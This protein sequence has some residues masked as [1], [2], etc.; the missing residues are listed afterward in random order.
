MPTNAK[1][2][3]LG[4][5]RPSRRRRSWKLCSPSQIAERK[6]NSGKLTAAVIAPV[7]H[8]QMSASARPR[9]RAIQFMLTSLRTVLCG[10][11]SKSRKADRPLAC[12]KSC[13]HRFNSVYVHRPTQQ[14]VV[15]ESAHLVPHARNESANEVAQIRLKNDSLKEELRSDPE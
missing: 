2:S 11:Q 14:C 7:Q 5:A 8:A 6:G 13:C 3:R 1:S 9:W 12:P 15:R 10:G 4:V